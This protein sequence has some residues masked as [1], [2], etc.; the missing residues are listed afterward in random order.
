MVI[1]KMA[2]GGIAQAGKVKNATPKVAKQER[3]EKHK[4]GRAKKREQYARFIDRQ[5]SG[6]RDG[7]NKQQKGKLG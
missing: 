1:I 7:P 5:E 4:T 6:T 3:T 2:H